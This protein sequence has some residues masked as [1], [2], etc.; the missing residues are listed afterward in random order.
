MTLKNKIGLFDLTMLVISF[1]IGMGIFRTPANV[2]AV[3][4]TAFIFFMSWVAGGLIALC[5]AL[6]YAE[7]GSRMPG[8]GHL[9][10]FNC[11]SLSPTFRFSFYFVLFRLSSAGPGWPNWQGILNCSASATADVA[12]PYP[13]PLR[14]CVLWLF[15]VFFASFAGSSSSLRFRILGE[16]GAVRKRVVELPGWTAASRPSRL[17]ASRRQRSTVANLSR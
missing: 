17:R 9:L 3:S 11:Y 15:G 8:K 5:G 10:K 2:A 4:P 1:V 13:D 6:T 12:R 14:L 16:K 7:I